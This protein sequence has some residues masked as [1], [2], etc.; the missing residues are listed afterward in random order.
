MDVTCALI[1]VIACVLLLSGSARGAMRMGEKCMVWFIFG[2]LLRRCADMILRCVLVSGTDTRPVSNKGMILMRVRICAMHSV[3]LCV[4]S[5]L[6]GTLD[7]CALQRL[8]G[9]TDYL[10]F[11]LECTEL[12]CIQCRRVLYAV[13]GEERSALHVCANAQTCFTFRCS[14][15][16][17]VGLYGF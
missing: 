15:L 6:S 3:T 16:Q 2:C 9:S 1:V 4:W 12:G 5:G 8:Q 10:L 11:T 13:H 7:L 14:L 17:F